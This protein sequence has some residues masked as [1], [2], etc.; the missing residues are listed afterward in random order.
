MRKLAIDLGTKRCGFAIS[1]SFNMMAFGL[2]NFSYKENDFD[3]LIEKIKKILNEYPIDT[4]ILGYPTKLSGEKIQMSLIVEEFKL[5][6]EK[7]FKIDV[8]LVDEN[9]TTK[10]ATQ[11]LIGANLSRKKRK[12]HKDKLA[13]QLILE[14]YLLWG[15]NDKEK[16]N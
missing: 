15:K 8:F 12:K 1:D 2:E 5:L 3:F 7:N 4:I 16:R 14:E 6:L 13:A 11:I 9:R 10:Q